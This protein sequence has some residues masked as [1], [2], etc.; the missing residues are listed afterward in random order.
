MLNHALS[1]RN[2][3]TLQYHTFLKKIM[4]ATSALCYDTVGLLS[5]SICYRTLPPLF[6]NPGAQ[7]ERDSRTLRPSDQP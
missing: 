7:S 4:V 2:T 5:L 3:R 6:G 1:I